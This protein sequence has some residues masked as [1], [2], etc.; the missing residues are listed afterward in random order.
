M[1][2]K[3]V[4]I[5]IPP[6]L[7]SGDAIAI[8]A[9]ARKI[10]LEEIEPAIKLFKSWGLKVVL[11]K[12]LF[13][14][15]NQF[16]GTEKERAED[17]QWALD[18]KKIKAVFCA[19]GGY[20]CVRIIDLLDFS[21]FI[22]HPKWIVGFSD[23]TVFHSHVHNLGI[24]SLHAAMP[25]NISKLLVNFNL[26]RETQDG[27]KITNYKL[28][29]TNSAT[30]N[31]QPTTHN[32]SFTALKDALFGST[33]LNYTLRPHPL[34]RK[35]KAKGVL[36][37]GNL[38]MLYSLT[39]SDS[40]IDT[41][42]KILFIE[43][44][45]EYLY[46]IDRMMMNLKRSGKLEHLAGLVVGGMTDMKDNKVAFNKTAEQ[47]I[48]EAVAEYDYPV[49]YHFPAGHIENNSALIMGKMV[50]LKVGK[51]VTLKFI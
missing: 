40:D 18:D 10:I 20:G 48:S 26:R 4:S 45:D 3:K 41:R 6:F 9:P 38:S 22:K 1:L 37:G 12:N 43:D 27:S 29:I 35:G 14:S 5:Q 8:V 32:L 30:H 24:G 19:R 44:L 25:Y 2:K 34:N 17:F 36:V 13:C 7:S 28:Q 21:A 49:C 16:A 51:N 50:E 15:Y 11:G 42:G 23:V 33:A 31:P 47:I 46:H 39:G